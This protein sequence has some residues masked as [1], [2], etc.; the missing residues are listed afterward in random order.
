VAEEFPE[1]PTVPDP[2]AV[3]PRRAAA[4]AEPARA[5]DSSAVAFAPSGRRV[6]ATR[7][8]QL[9]PP[10]APTP[11]E[12]AIDRA[13]A[14]AVA[15]H[16]AA[17]GTRRE[18]PA[19]AER[20]AELILN[21]LQQC[22]AADPAYGVLQAER[23]PAWKATRTACDLVLRQ[24]AEG[25]AALRTGVLVLTASR[26]TGIV[27]YLRRLAEEEQPFDRLF[28][29]PE[30]GVGLP[31]GPRGQEY[32]RELQERSSVQLHT[33]ELGFAEY[34]GMA[35]LRAAVRQARGG[36]LLAGEGD[37]VSEAEVI[38]SHHRR[39]RYQASRFLSALL[40]EAPPAELPRPAPALAQ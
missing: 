34:A 6:L 18:V 21:L 39:Q 40:F 37:R 20:V 3:R 36:T 38:A 32:L 2:N 4:P 26:A 28:L 15:D 29:I 13:V 31:L 10:P 23:V 8:W 5:T 22:R 33:L 19:D 7:A 25:G 1:P 12:E 14:A 35:S 17:R 11:R 24:Q 9:P 16:L 30:E 27:G